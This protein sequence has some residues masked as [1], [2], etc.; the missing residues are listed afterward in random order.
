MKDII[1]YF[2]IYNIWNTEFHTQHS[3]L[4]SV[5][6]TIWI[7]INIIEFIAEAIKRI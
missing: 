1:F 5:I 2:L 6:L 3:T 7:V 4:I